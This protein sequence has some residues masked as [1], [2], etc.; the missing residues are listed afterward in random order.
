MKDYL[1][2]G[3]GI[4]GT[5]L[6]WHLLQA[7]KDILVIDAPRPHTASRIAAGIINPVSGRRFELAWAYDRIYPFA[8]DTYR[9]MGVLLGTEAFVERDIWTV[10]P[11]AQ[12]EAAFHAKTHA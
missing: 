9:E 10:F 4:A 6:S 5:L 1:I 8:R 7:Q 12:M 2:I 3:Q 11:S